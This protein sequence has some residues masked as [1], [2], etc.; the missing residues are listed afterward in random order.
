MLLSFG[1]CLLAILMILLLLM[2]AQP[3]PN[4][5][6]ERIDALVAQLGDVKFARRESAVRELDAIGEKAL[7]ALHTAVD[8]T[9]DVEIRLRAQQTIRLIMIGA[10]KSKSTGLETTYIEP[11]MFEMGSSSTEPNRQKDEDLHQIR[12]LRPFLLGTYEVTQ[13]EYQQVMKKNPSWFSPGGKGKDKIIGYKS[14]RFP[15]DSVSWFDSIEFCNR[16]SKMDS[17]PEY[18][19]TTEVKREDDAIRS[20]TVKIVGGAGYRLP[21]EA[22]WEYAC[23]AKSPLPFHFGRQN[24]GRE[25]NLKPGPPT[26]YGGG[27]AFNPLNRTTIVSSYPANL[28]GLHVMHGNV[29]EWCWD[30]YDKDYY[31]KSPKQDPTG[32]ESG[33]HRVLRGGS[34]SVLEGNGRSATRFLLSPGETQYY[35]GFRVARSP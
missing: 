14:D 11:G 23:R 24:T 27:P 2:Q 1:S 18:Y 10:R 25:A 26:G 28:W 6:A 9:T 19:T 20:A 13:D 4:P 31:L 5:E 7:P 3:A 12:I 29:A 15:V 34:W 33:N 30:W 35:A 17:Y 32:P 8:Q 22:E 16:L 21:T